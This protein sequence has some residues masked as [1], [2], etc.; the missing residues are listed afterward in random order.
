VFDRDQGDYPTA[1]A[2]GGGLNR[3]P[4][5]ERG[6]E[7]KSRKRIVRY[8][9]GELG[10]YPPRPHSQGRRGTEVERKSRGDAAAIK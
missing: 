9:D 4:S 10:D 7:E 3:A 6:T 1:P 8:F 2:T 5:W